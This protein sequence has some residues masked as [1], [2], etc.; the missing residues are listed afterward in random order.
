ML[1][2]INLR[3]IEVIL[4][5]F[6]GIWDYGVLDVFFYRIIWVFF[7]S[8]DK[9]EIILNGDE[10]ILMFENLNFNIVYEV[11]IIVIY[12]DELESDDLIGSECILFILII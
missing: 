5:G 4:E 8:L 9:M 2:L 11:F 12:F 10:N 6:R 7:G 1:V 3:I